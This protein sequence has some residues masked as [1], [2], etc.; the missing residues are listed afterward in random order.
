MD[1]SKESLFKPTTTQKSALGVCS[2]ATASV[3]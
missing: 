1:S 2:S 3:T